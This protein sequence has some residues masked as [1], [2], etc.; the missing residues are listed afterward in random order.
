MILLDSSHNSWKNEVLLVK[1]WAKVLDLWLDILLG[2]SG[3]NV[4]SRSQAPRLK[5]FLR[6][7]DFIGFI[8]W[9]L[10]NW[11]PVYENWS[12]GSWFMAGYVFYSLGPSAPNL[13][14]SPQV[15][16]SRHFLRFHDF[17]GLISL[18][19]RKW[20]L[21]CDNIGGRVLD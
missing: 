20:G 7:Y 11:G 21:A 2:P 5:F 16:R 8:S 10:R 4:V 17:I 12:Q 14:S 1:I 3:P 9:F 15:P 19:L 6:F 13:V 18:F